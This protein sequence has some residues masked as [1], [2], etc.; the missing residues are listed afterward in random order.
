M[1]L[2]CY[3]ETWKKQI[4]FFREMAATVYGTRNKKFRMILLTEISYKN[5]GCKV[6]NGTYL[7]E[8]HYTH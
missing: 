6:Q 5:C 2:Q 3:L 7:N 1:R 8:R 4:K